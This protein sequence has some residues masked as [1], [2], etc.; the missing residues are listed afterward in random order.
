[1][2]RETRDGA[3]MMG[4]EVAPESLEDFRSLSRQL[5]GD[6]SLIFIDGLEHLIEHKQRFAWSDL[7]ELY[8]RLD[9]LLESKGRRLEELGTDPQKLPIAGAVGKALG[10]VA[11]P[12]LLYTLGNRFGLERTFSHL[13]V[14]ERI[15]PDGRIRI[16]I[17]VPDHYEPSPECFRFTAGLLEGLPLMLGLEPADVEW[18]ATSHTATYLVMP[19]TSRTL[20]NRINRIFRAIVAPHRT[21]QELN[22]QQ[23]ALNRKHRELK[24]AYAQVSD[25]LQV[26]QR[27]LRVISHEL[28]TPLNGIAGTSSLL[29]AERDPQSVDPL[30][31][32]LQHST[33]RLSKLVDEMLDFVVMNGGE[34]KVAPMDVNFESSLKAFLVAHTQEARRKHLTL[35]LQ[36]AHD[37]PTKVR[38]D[39]L[40]LLR[41]IGQLID[42]A[43]K[44]THAGS[45][46]LALG[47]E[48]T[49][50]TNGYIHFSISDTGPG[51][52]DRDQATI[53]S[54][55]EQGDNTSTR[56]EGGTGLGLALVHRSIK[57]LGGEIYLV[58]TLGVGSRFTV[59]VP[60][61]V[62]PRPTT[63]SPASPLKG[64]ILVVDDDRINRMLLQRMVQKEG[65]SVDLAED[66]VEAVDMVQQNVYDLVFMDCEMPNMDGWEATRKIRDAGPLPPIVA[67]TAYV[68]PTDR[69]RCRDAGMDGFLAKPLSVDLVKGML[70]RWASPPDTESTSTLASTA[71]PN[72]STVRD[73]M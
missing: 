41:A 51:I 22:D 27:F 19:P 26:R 72:A 47:F 2:R 17:G 10:V 56:A 6:A 14:S 30:F 48:W 21:L 28:R 16:E 44:F 49:S 33:G 54:L 12:R 70:Q 25:A 3:T 38:L 64:R 68:T 7:C 46:T 31:D 32:A 65:F 4:E 50:E 73:S 69:E 35:D 58:S 71:G 36:V 53:F 59:R 67:A 61:N 62:L 37:F 40:R 60:T 24:A 52:P 39:S 13:K 5:T 15:F 66:G 42:N 29:R 57:L 34:A 23:Q 55:F 18:T 43:I 11:S 9:R 63:P 45:I 20:W 1:M 8:R